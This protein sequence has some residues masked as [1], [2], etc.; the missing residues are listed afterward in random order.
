M[1]LGRTQT[2]TAP[3]FG[4]YDY[5]GNQIFL[6]TLGGTSDDDY[7]EQA[8]FAAD[9]KS[10]FAVGTYLSST[11]RPPAI[12]TAV[13]YFTLVKI[14]LITY[15]VS[16]QVTLNN[17]YSIY[18]SNG[19][20]FLIDKKNNILV[21]GSFPNFGSAPFRDNMFLAKFQ[22]N[23]KD[24]ACFHTSTNFNA[25]FVNM[26]FAWE[27]TNIPADYSTYSEDGSNLLITA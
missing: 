6:K 19:N 13:S 27:V 21:A 8:Q 22:A 12:S 9:G 20:A 17:A 3:F 24:W 14:N 18:G 25:Q 16:A 23:L 26:P 15:E 10:L 4:Y 2:I 11:F 1:I 7:L 5:N